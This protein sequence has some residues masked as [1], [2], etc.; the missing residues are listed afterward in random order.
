MLR[1]KL[2]NTLAT[3][4]E[5]LTDTPW[6]WERLKPEEM[7]TTEDEMVRWHHWLDGHE[8]EQA[9][10]VGDGQGSLEGCSPWVHRA[11]HDW[12]TELNWYICIYMLFHINFHYSLSQDI[13]YSSLCC[14]VGPCCLSVLYIVVSKAMSLDC[15]G[16]ILII[17]TATS[18]NW[19][20][21]VI[22]QILLTTFYKLNSYRAVCFCCFFFF[23]VA[24]VHNPV[25]C[26]VL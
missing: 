10:G 9:P 24:D 13:E 16:W 3:W 19:M 2:H 7:G 26:S 1:L 18:H 14:T 25:S 21:E 15:R 5:E 20:S 23:L 11:G 6:C 8:F 4:C 22:P 17:F 12:V